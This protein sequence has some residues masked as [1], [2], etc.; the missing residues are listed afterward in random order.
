M[1]VSGAEIIVK[2]LEMYGMDI[3]AGIP[4]GATLPLYNALYGSPIRHILT[5]HEQG[6]GFIAHGI[7]RSTGRPAACI[8]TSGPGATNLVTPLAD[9]KLDSVPLMAFTGQVSTPLIGTDAF[10]EVDTYGMTLPITKHNFL[11]KSASELLRVIPGGLAICTSGRPGPVLIDVPKD[12][13]LETVEVPMWPE[14]PV[15]RNNTS[16]DISAIEEAAGL[17][18]A[19]ERPVLYVGGGIIASGCHDDLACLARKNSIPLVMTLMGL[20]C[21]PP[22]D[23]LYLGMLGMHAAPFTNRIVHEADLIVAIGA[24]FDDRAIGRAEE[25]CPGAKIVHVDIDG[26]EINKVKNAHV[27]II[28]DAGVVIRLLIDLV[29][30]NARHHWLRGVDRLRDIFPFRWP[31]DA[32]APVNVIRDIARVAPADTVVAT[33]VGQHQMWVA[34]AYPFRFPRSL[35]TSGGLGC[36][37]FGLP[38]A[39][40]A[41]LANPDR[42]VLCISGDGSFQMNMQEMATLAELGLSVTVIIMNN[43]HLGLVRQQQELFYEKRFMASR[44][45]LRLD[46]AAL[47]QQYG[48]QGLRVTERQQLRPALAAAF[49][50]RRPFVI[51]IAVHHAENVLPIV[52]PG[53]A[54]TEMI[55]T[56][57]G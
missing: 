6:A 54:N 36:M 22:D 8:A 11:V 42:H 51:D 52:P 1:R 53:R 55:E 21:F 48:I 38:A 40:G 33:D 44:F 27:S 13:Q 4:G 3:V 45:G 57:A 47:A 7:A 41:A 10:Q 23:P 25:F 26:A 29:E 43:G 34:Q 35:L 24:R 30:R 56:L 14:I 17:I 20:G 37:G 39:I 31:A 2:L 50:D 19:A 12:V 46:F 9:A 49:A 16:P 5:R 18:N 15:R 32:S 28:A